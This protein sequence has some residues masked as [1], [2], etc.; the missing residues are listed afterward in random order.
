VVRELIGEAGAP[1]KLAVDVPHD[2]VLEL[3]ARTAVVV[4]THRGGGPFGMPRSVVEGMLAQTSVILPDRPEAALVAGTDCRTY[5]R[6]SDIVRHVTEILAGGPHITHEQQ[7]NRR[8]AAQHFADPELA[9]HFVAQVTRSVLEW[10][11]RQ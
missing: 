5:A 11:A 2:Q 3:L 8:F 4:Y 9:A 7:A 10:R 6:A 1:V